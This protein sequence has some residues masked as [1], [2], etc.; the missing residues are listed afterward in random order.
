MKNAIILFFLS[1]IISAEINLRFQPDLNISNKRIIDEK[2][3]DSQYDVPFQ[4]FL[5]ALNENQEIN[6]EVEIASKRIIN[7]G[8][9]LDS[10]NLDNYTKYTAK[11][12]SQ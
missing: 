5:L 4:T 2:T 12:H 8:E 10:F 3:K 9:I 1:L 11:C 6:L 7:E